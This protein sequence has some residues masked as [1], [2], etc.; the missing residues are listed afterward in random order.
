MWLS[1][2]ARKVSSNANHHRDAAAQPRK[3]E[4]YQFSLSLP[5]LLI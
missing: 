5:R 2:A 1:W 3:A 4:L